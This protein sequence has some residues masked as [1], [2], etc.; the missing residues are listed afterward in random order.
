MKQILLVVAAALAILAGCTQAAEP[1]TSVEV[2]ADFCDSLQAFGENLTQIEQVTPDMTLDD[3]LAARQAVVVSQERLLQAADTLSGAR[4][5]AIKD[6]WASLAATIDSVADSA[7]LA[8]KTGDILQGATTVRAAYDQLARAACPELALAE[9]TEP[10]VPV[11]IA[12]PE[13]SDSLAPGI[14]GRYA[15][16]IPAL[17]GSQQ[18]ATL[19]L[20]EGGDASMVFSGAPA[21]DGTEQ[22]ISEVIL[23]GTWKE[24]ADATV[25]VTLNRL[26]DGIELAVAEA[27]T[28]RRDDDQLVAVEFDQEIYGP[29]GLT[30]RRV[31]ET[32]VGA[33]P[34]SAEE[35][36][37]QAGATEP[38]ATETGSASAAADNLTGVTWQLQQIQQ[39]GAGTTTDITSGVYT[40]LLSPD[41]SLTA[42]ADC[43]SGA[44]TF[45]QRDSQISFQIDWSAGLCP[46]PSLQ[47]QFSKYLEYADVYTVQDGTLAIGFSNGSGTLL[48]RAAGQ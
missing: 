4:T 16:E 39:A 41:G 47:R 30:L 28:F 18:T 44:G 38:N 45:A 21:R 43:S 25:A 40:L 8:A 19:T 11:Q 12:Q 34:A 31:D 24:N 42:Q 36:G 37:E 26:A 17:D 32:V 23:E 35:G 27:F 15:G 29:A 22:A 13:A 7:A 1:E 5:D 6:A 9:D 20:H 14:P 3:L 46:Q 48:F 10:L 33:V 2:S